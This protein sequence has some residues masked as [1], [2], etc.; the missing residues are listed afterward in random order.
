LKKL[1]LSSNAKVNIG[2]KIINE[3]SDGYHNIQ[4]L[5]QEIDFSD[6]ITF[7][8]RDQG[9]T[10]SIDDPRI[11][12][13]DSNTCI[14][15]Y[16]VLKNQFPE[17]GG[18]ALKLQKSIPSGAGLGGGSSNAATVLK[19][20]NLLYKL[21][22]ERKTME[23]L[24]FKIGA[25][26][27]FFIKGGTQIGKGIGEKLT[28]AKLI[29]GYYLLVIPQIAINTKGAYSQIKKG[30]NLS[31]HKYKFAS[32]LKEF[33]D[34]F[35]FIQNDFEQVI[36]PAYPE[37]GRIKKMLSKLGANFSSLSGSGST[38]FGIFDEE[39]DAYSAQSHFQTKYKTI[40]SSPVQS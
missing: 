27:P 10:L 31:K 1:I 20:L 11:P 15:A 7:C 21:G 32:S 39:A 38:V 29:E 40:L 36:I 17:I 35:T 12:N 25:D 13:D 18:I 19:G 4:T 28:R 37:I 23:N 6:Q 34:S 9:C 24:A 26:A 33:D 5:F 16:Q 22:M 8:V 2:L 14:Q 30:L 3:R